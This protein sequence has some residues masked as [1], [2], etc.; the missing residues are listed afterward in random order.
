MEYDLEDP[1]KV[2][3]ESAWREVNCPKE[4]EFL[5]RLRNQRHF[6]QAKG[7]L[8]TMSTMKKRFNWSTLTVKAEMVLEGEYS[9]PELDEIQQLFFDNLTRV[10][11]TDKLVKLIIREEFRGKMKAL[12]ESMSTSPSRRHLGH[13]KSLIST[14]DRSL[15]EDERKRLKQIQQE[16]MSCYIDVI[17]YA[18]KLRYLLECWRTIMNN[19]IYKEPGNVEIH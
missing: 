17:N 15:D 5:L 18:I 4:I 10:I 3:D 7:T 1:K 14:I 13:Y 2:K 16:L 11:E 12:R 8:F 9:E 19:M 6:G